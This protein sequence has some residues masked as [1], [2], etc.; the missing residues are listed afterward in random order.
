MMA[1]KS[2]LLVIDANILRSAGETEHPVSSACRNFLN[3]V[4]EICDRMVLTQQIHKEWKEHASR[5]SRKWRRSMAARRKTVKVS[6]KEVPLNKTSLSD[7][8]CDIIEKDWH[9]V[10]A[11][12]AADGIIVTRDKEFR[13]VLEKT[14]HGGR[15]KCIKWVNP[16]K[17]SGTFFN[18]R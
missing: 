17:E 3:R 14:E 5:F 6:P 16:V 11:A 13:R 7:K 18:S 8:D 15:L 12:F 10:E 2:R 1:V 4:L 9:L